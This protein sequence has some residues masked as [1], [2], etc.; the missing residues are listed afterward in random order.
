[1]PLAV[2]ATRVSRRLLD[3][4]LILLICLALATLVIA[5][6]IPSLT[7][8]A[9]FVVGG[10]SMA[11]AIPLGSA[12]IATPVA[13][14]DLRPG[15]VVSLQ[16]GAQRAIFT[17]RITRVV[18]RD[19]GLWLE[20]RGD[21]NPGPDPSLVPAGDVIGRVMAVI[22]WA[23]YVVTLLS[24]V[25]GVVFLVSLAGFLLAGAWLL[26]TLESDQRAA[27]RRRA[28]AGLAALGPEPVAGQGA[29]G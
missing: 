14:A 11:P 18:T 29:T 1:M 12:V 15:D 24:S 8:G 7:G 23:G 21:A 25:Q 22:P 26:D 13:A 2:I 9:T 16:V 10:G 4:L 3:V 17:H 19:D 5:R 20:T 27:L 6:V 28:A